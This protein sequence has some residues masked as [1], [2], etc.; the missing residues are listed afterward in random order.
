MVVLG[1]GAGA[2][3]LVAG[4][5]IRRSL[6]QRRLAARR[7]VMTHPLA[8]QLRVLALEAEITRPIRL[9]ATPLLASPIALG[10]NEITVPEAALT[11]L[12]PDQQRGMLA[13]ELAHLERR[14]PAWLTAIGLIERVAFFQPLNRIARKRFQECAEYLCDEWAVRQTGEDG[15]HSLASCLAKVAE[16]LETAPAIPVAGMAEE[17]SHLVGRVRRLLEGAP[18]SHGPDRRTVLMGGGLAVA[19]AVMAVPAVSTGPQAATSQGSELRL[20]SSSKGADKSLT[21]EQQDSLRAVVRALMAAAKDPEVEVRRAALQSLARYE[22]RSSISV[23]REALRDQDQEI[24]STAIEALAE[25]KDR[26]SVG[27]IAA[28]LR[29]ENVEVRRS[30]AEAM[31]ELPARGVMD[32]LIVAL[33]DPDAEVREGIVRALENLKDPAA[34]GPLVLAL[35]DPKP[36]VRARAVSAL[37]ELDL[38]NPPSPLLEMLRDQNADVRHEAAHA[39]A[40][41]KDVR[42]VPILRAMLEDP[43][44]EV[45]EAAVDA[46]S[47]IRN[48]EAL[49]A[50]M[51]ALKSKD[52]KVRKAAA[53]ALG[54]K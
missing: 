30:A 43:D 12:D 48:D 8:D 19:L 1:W 36:K 16:W 9:T 23:F 38:P 29:D 7:P 5:L 4:Y 44:G 13:H 25:F 28:M 41:Y 51:G 14:D 22:D 27:E 50:L 2:L 34:E 42:A 39:V 10:H 18:F 46:L 26:S 20:D 32:Q 31:G 37:H 49:A 3:L 45:R 6:W 15:G 21:R 11:E 33:R 35:K 54:Q 40:H 53:E 47:D 52:P 17:R 24:R